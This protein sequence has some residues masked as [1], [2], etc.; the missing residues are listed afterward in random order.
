MTFVRVGE[1]ESVGGASTEVRGYTTTGTFN[2]GWSVHDV[3]QHYQ[4]INVAVKALTKKLKRPSRSSPV[5][6]G[7]SSEERRD[8]S[9]QSVASPFNPPQNSYH[10]HD[11]W[12]AIAEQQV[13][14]AGK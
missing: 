2:F 7:K 8:R 1:F 10:H 13:C 6:P 3:R 12:P 4:P 14:P 9:V 5:A 11:I